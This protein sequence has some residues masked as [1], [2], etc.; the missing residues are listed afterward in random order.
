VIRSA[1]RHLALLEAQSTRS[2]DQFDLFSVQPINAEPE[3]NEADAAF[4]AASSAAS[5]STALQDAVTAIDPD[6]LSPREALEALYQLKRLADE[7]DS[8]A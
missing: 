3:A 6:Q 8:K 1:R 5:F 7:P 4:G 2:D